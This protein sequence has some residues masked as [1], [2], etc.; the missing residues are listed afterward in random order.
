MRLKGILVSTLAA[1]AVAGPALAGEY[2]LVIEEKTVNVTGR[3]R[4]AMTVNGSIPGPVLRMREGE[5]VTISYVDT[6]KVLFTARAILGA[7][8]GAIRGSLRNC[9]DASPSTS[10]VR[11]APRAAARALRLRLPLRAL[12]PRAAPR[13]QGAHPQP[14]SGGPGPGRAA[15]RRV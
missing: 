9:S 10:A 11:G 7:I 13:P 12:R 14:L 5:E 8:L 3:E 2:D 4:P 15:A 6:S 1:L